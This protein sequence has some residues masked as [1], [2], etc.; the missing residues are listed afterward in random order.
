MSYK[1]VQVCIQMLV[2]AALYYADLTLQ[3]HCNANIER[4]IQPAGNMQPQLKL[5]C[6]SLSSLSVYSKSTKLQT[7]RILTGILRVPA[8]LWR[9]VACM[10]IC[11]SCTL[12]GCRESSN[13]NAAHLL[14]NMKVKCNLNFRAVHAAAAQELTAATE[15]CSAVAFIPFFTILAPLRTNPGPGRATCLRMRGIDCQELN[16]DIDMV[17]LTGANVALKCMAAE[18][19]RRSAK[20]RH[21]CHGQKFSQRY[22]DSTRLEGA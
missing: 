20:S 9:H 13:H 15:R 12:L 4:Q 18:L 5:I 22:V 1:T 14:L 3:N 2:A 19:S 6:V 11:S 8:A 7:C 10:Q 16:D 21:M 17:N